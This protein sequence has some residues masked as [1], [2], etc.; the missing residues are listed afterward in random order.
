[1]DRERLRDA[2]LAGG[3]LVGLLILLDR[4]DGWRALRDP[5]AAATGVAT[6]LL[7]EWAF[8]RYPVRLLSLWERPVVNRGLPVVLLTV[9]RRWR[10]PRV[11]AAGV[12]GLATYVVLFVRLALRQHGDG[13]T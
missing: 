9:A 5:R 2:G 12:W 13:G 4:S 10:Q 1:M 8:L 6:A 3:M 7:V 11:L